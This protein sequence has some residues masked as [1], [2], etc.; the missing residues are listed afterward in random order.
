MLAA[1]GRREPRHGNWWFAP[2]PIFHVD[3]TDWAPGTPLVLDADTPGHPVARLGDLPDGDWSLQGVIRTSPRAASALTGPGTVHSRPVRVKVQG[4]PQ[5]TMTLDKVEP[6]RPLVQADSGMTIFQSPSPLLSTHF[7]LPFNL[8]AAVRLPKGHDPATRLP[9]LYV[10]GGFPG[11]LK[12]APMLSWMFG[13]EADAHG[14]AMVYLEAEYFGGHSAFVNGEASGPWADALVTEFIPA[15]EAALP[16]RTDRDGRFLTG[17]SSGG[18][19]TLWLALDQPNTFGGT[20]STAPDPVSFNR[21]QT[22]DIHAP[23]ANIYTRHDGGDAPIARMP[24]GVI[25]ARDFIRTET[26]FGEGGQM[27]SFEWTFSPRGEDGLPL[28]LWNRDTGKIDP[29]VANAWRHY[30]INDRV[31]REWNTLEPILRDRVLVIMG[32][33]DTFHLEG[34]AEQLDATLT[35]RGLSDVVELVPGDHSSVLN[36]ATVKRVFKRM[37]QVARPGAP[38]TPPAPSQP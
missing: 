10:I 15:L 7:G 17:H 35:A 38:P 20:L 22:V 11:S 26:A 6:Q 24:D 19:A 32:N 33:A 21:F 37:M 34:A 27:R 8:R 16:L 14:V 30:D 18:W 2:N 12:S 28:P 13:P 25:L 23:D 5:A 3:V 4:T 31:Q 1:Q 29:A 9:T 36:P